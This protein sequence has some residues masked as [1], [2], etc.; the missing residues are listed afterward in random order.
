MANGPQNLLVQQNLRTPA[1]CHRPDLFSFQL[2]CCLPILFTSLYGLR[3]YLNLPPKSHTTAISRVYGYS[4]EAAVLVSVNLAFQ[5]FDFIV[6][7]FIPEHF[8]LIPMCHHF[9]AGLVLY[10]W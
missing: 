2:T 7:P 3:T 9:L 6:S 10:L 4:K 8:A 1:P 5:V